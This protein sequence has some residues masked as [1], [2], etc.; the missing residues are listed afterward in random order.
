MHSKLCLH[1]VIFIFVW[2]GLL[3]SLSKLTMGKKD[4]SKESGKEDDGQKQRKLTRNQAIKQANREV[5]SIFKF[6]QSLIFIFSWV[7]L[8]QISCHLVS[9]AMIRNWIED[10]RAKL[11]MNWPNIWDLLLRSTSVGK[12][13]EQSMRELLVWYLLFRTWKPRLTVWSRW[14][15]RC[16][17]EIRQPNGKAFC[18]SVFSAM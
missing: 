8:L 16:P 10:L 3:H 4:T 13:H 9:L 17:V 15:S 12:S 1:T 5:S 7:A 18:W 6:T 2:Y 11:D 14:Q